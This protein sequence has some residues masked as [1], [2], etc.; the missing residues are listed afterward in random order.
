MKIFRG[1]GNTSTDALGRY[2]FRTIRPV[3]YPGRTPHIH[4]AVFAQGESPFVTQLYVK[5]DLRNQQ[6]FLF[7]RLPRERQH[8][9]LAD[10]K[11]DSQSQAELKAE[12]DIILNRTDGTPQQSS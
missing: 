9:V 3:V 5:G 2:R 8:L 11:P 7:R 1:H 12:F 6:D 10:F 4:I